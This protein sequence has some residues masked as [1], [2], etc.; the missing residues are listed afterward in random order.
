M[1]VKNRFKGGEGGRGPFITSTSKVV[2]ANI[3]EG[4]LIPFGARLL[5]KR[6]YWISLPSYFLFYGKKFDHR[7]IRWKARNILLLSR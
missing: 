2:E 6:D 1:Y 7:T 4:I 5:N 3:R